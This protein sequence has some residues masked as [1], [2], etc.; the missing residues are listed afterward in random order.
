[1]EE[2]HS[3]TSNKK[4]GIMASKGNRDIKFDIRVETPKGVLS[5]AYIK[6]NDSENEVATEAS[7]V[8]GNSAPVKDVTEIKSVLKLNIDRA[9]AILGHANE[10]TTQKTAE[11]LN[12]QTTRDRSKHVSPV[13]LQRPSK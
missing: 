12:M 8:N 6:R 7:D 5:C 9:H 4:T 3:I 11:V 10:D 13:Q 2:G 1:M